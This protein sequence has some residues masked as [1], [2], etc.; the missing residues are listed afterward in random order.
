[1]RQKNHNLDF[2]KFGIATMFFLHALIPTT[3]YGRFGALINE[4]S[5]ADEN[6]TLREEDITLLLL[7]FGIGVIVCILFGAVFLTRKMNN[8]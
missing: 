3:L 5:P 6:Q 1:L 7:S 4:F 8:K 2:A